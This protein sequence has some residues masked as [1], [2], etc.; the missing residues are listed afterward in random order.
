MDSHIYIAFYGI[1]SIILIIYFDRKKAVHFPESPKRVWVGSLF[2]TL[3]QFLL[4]FFTPFLIIRKGKIC[5][6]CYPVGNIFQGILEILAA[7]IDKDFAAFL[8]ME[9]P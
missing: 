4:I 6:K 3:S 5:F 1:L 7:L 8:V 9:L 2:R